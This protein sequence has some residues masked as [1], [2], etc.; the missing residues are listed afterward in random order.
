MAQITQIIEMCVGGFNPSIAADTYL[1]IPD[2]ATR[3]NMADFDGTVTV[4]FEANIW[5]NYST[6]TH[7]TTAELYNH[8]DSASVSGSQVSTSKNTGD[9]DRQ[10]S[11]A[12]T[13]SGDKIYTVRL[14]RS[15]AAGTQSYITGARLIVVQTGSI[16][17]TQIHHELGYELSSSSTSS[18]NRLTQAMLFLYEAAKYDGTVTVRHDANIK[19]TSGNTTTTGIYDE[20]ATSIVSSS[21]VATTSTSFGVQSSSDITLTDGHVYRPTSYVSAGSAVFFESNKLVFTIT[22]SPTKFLA[23]MEAMSYD[24]GSGG[25]STT[26]SSYTHPNDDHPSLTTADFSGCT[27]AYYH[28]ALFS[29][30]NAAQTATATVFTGVDGSYTDL[31]ATEVTHTGDTNTVRSR[32]SAFTPPVGANEIG[33]GVKSSGGGATA[34]LYKSFIILEITDLVPAAN[35]SDSVTVTDYPNSYSDTVFTRESYTVQIVSD[36]SDL[37]VSVSD[38]VTVSESLKTELNSF[39]NVSDS[40]TVTENTVADLTIA[41]SVND[42]ITVSEALH[43]ELNSFVAVVDNITVTGA[44]SLL[45]P[46]LL[47]TATDSI[48][49][50]ESLQRLLESYISVSDSATV[51]ESVN[52]VLENNVN[53]SDSSTLTESLQRLLESRINVN[54][55]A[56]VSES[57]SVSLTNAND[58][59]ITLA[60][61]VTVSEVITMLET[62]FIAVSDMVTATEALQRTLVSDVNVSDSIT[63][64]ENKT[65]QL[66]SFITVSDSVVVSESTNLLIPT[67]FIV[68]SDGVTV[69]ES[70][71]V[72]IEGTTTSTAGLLSLLGAG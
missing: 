11:S 70:V 61:T 67:L 47:I 32:S 25:S 4:Y 38:S 66:S 24:A 27:V 34:R 1:E 59:N 20:T 10:R 16:T 33:A 35:V 40:T 43:A 41:L 26:G 36:G 48:T 58:L 5:S 8:T 63:V 69:S 46:F 13:L 15:D 39:I 57:I 31:A 23:Y 22:G 9:V 49:V 65:A 54:D 64:S 21:E 6:G 50:S 60:D 7:T 52:R 28:E 53:V 29:I 62:S 12:I 18:S 72:S 30:S 14:K 2:I 3:L 55:P 68:A 51:S 56:A 17:K 37:A 19:A 42:N 71:S 44:T 45:I